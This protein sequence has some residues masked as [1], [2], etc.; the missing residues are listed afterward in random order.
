MPR[1]SETI[2][3]V[4]DET[5]VRQLTREILEEHGYEVLEAG[6]GVGALKV[7]DKHRSRVQLLFTDIVMPEGISGLDLAARLQ[8]PR[9]DL[10][11]IFTSG[12]SA[13]LAGRELNLREGQ[14]FLAKPSRPHEIFA[15]VRRCLDS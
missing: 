12:Y 2:L 13:D 7:W 3:V 9:P 5:V 15:A 6:L 14:N 10:K 1:G 4:E 11:V 8:V